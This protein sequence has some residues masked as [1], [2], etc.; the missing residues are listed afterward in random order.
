VLT[1][2]AIEGAIAVLGSLLVGVPVGLGLAVLTVRVLGLFFMLPPPL[3]SLP[4]GALAGLVVLMIAA[5]P[6]ALGIAL[7]AVTR[8]QTA[9]VLREP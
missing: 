2:P 4:V 6:L 9:S 1:G 7:V 3:L 5:S 8:M